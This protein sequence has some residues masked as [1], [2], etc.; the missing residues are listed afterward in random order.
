LPRVLGSASHNWVIGS[1]VIS[2]V[3]HPGALL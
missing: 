3:T 1:S 2:L